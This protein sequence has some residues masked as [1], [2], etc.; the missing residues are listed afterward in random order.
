METFD[1]LPLKFYFRNMKKCRRGARV[2][3]NRCQTSYVLNIHIYFQLLSPFYTIFTGSACN[4]HNHAE[5]NWPLYCAG[6]LFLW[7]F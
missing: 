7:S 5:E 4:Y 3:D 6:V 1:F 2:T